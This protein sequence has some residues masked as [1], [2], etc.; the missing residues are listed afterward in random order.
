MR[1]GEDSFRDFKSTK[2]RAEVRSE[3]ESSRAPM[4][5]NSESIGTES[6]DIGVH[7]MPGSRYTGKTRQEVRDELIQYQKTHKPNSPDD[8]YFGG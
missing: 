4:N 2:S 5:L 1:D 3:L 6:R 8:L 7:G